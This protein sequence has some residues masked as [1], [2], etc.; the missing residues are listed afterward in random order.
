MRQD[1]E[2]YNQALDCGKEGAW[3]DVILLLRQALQVN[4]LEAEYHSLM[5]V[6]CLGLELKALAIYHFRQAYKLNAF[7]PLLAHYLPF[8]N[9]DD[10]PFTEIPRSPHPLMPSAGAEAEPDNGV[11]Q[12]P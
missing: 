5:G 6:G 10:P 3:A 9:D 11:S 4:N 12:V 7:D 8:L 2:L 1:I